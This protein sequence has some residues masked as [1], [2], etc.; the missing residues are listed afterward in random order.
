LPIKKASS[1]LS[2]SAELDL[3]SFLKGKDRACIR[4]PKKNRCGKVCKDRRP[5]RSRIGY[6]AFIPRPGFVT[7][8]VNGSTHPH[9]PELFFI[10]KSHNQKYYMLKSH[11]PQKKRLKNG[12]NV[13]GMRLLPYTKYKKVLSCITSNF[14]R[15]EAI[16]PFYASYKIT[17]KCNMKC[18]FCNVWM[19]KTPVLPTEDVFKVLDNLANSSV[20]LV[21]LEGGEPL[22]R[23]DLGE[24]LRYAS[25][26]PFY[27]FFT[28]NGLLLDRAPMEEYGKYID[29]LHI[30]IDEGHENLDMLERLSEFQRY[31]PVCVQT[32]VTRN[33]MGVLEDKVQQVYKAGARTVIMPAVHLDKTD[34]FYPEPSDFKA[35]ISRLKKKYKNTIT[36]PYGYL[37]RINQPHG[38]STSSIIIDCDGKIFYP[39]RILQHKTCDLTKTPLM[40]YLRSEEA[41]ELR[42]QMVNCDR[43]CGWY[44]YFATNSFTSPREFLSSIK[45]YYDDFLNNGRQGKTSC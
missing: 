5:N 39:C 27:I 20:T 12:L 10:D 2:A 29:Y 22:R 4:L 9:H 24:I 28:T 41:A 19:E 32:V 14:F 21:S 1:I 18:K 35:E 34:N 38:C 30:S 3:P 44:Q 26:K 13:M 25:T 11:I 42:T 43:Q 6:D 23:K 31:A 37:N 8:L 36:T 45:P 33:D 7:L 15:G 40:D 17:N 16:Y